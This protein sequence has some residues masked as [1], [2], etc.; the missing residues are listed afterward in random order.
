VCGRRRA[1]SAQWYAPRV[2][3]FVNDTVGATEDGG[4]RRT[5]AA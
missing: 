4:Q 2:S 1:I 3:Y 5:V